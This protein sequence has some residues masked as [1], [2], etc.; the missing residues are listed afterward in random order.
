MCAGVSKSRALK[1]KEITLEQE[2]NVSKNISVPVLA[3]HLAPTCQ[4]TC[5]NFHDVY[6]TCIQKTNV[7]RSL[8]PD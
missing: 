6:Y 2:Y 5:R 7:I 3:F 8:Q 1:K 4:L